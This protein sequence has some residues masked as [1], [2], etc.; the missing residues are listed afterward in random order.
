MT[1]DPSS[2]GAADQENE[3]F[4]ANEFSWNP[5]LMHYGT[6]VDYDEPCAYCVNIKHKY[7]QKENFD[8]PDASWKKMFLTHPTRQEFYAHVE[9]LGIHG[10]HNCNYRSS[11]VD[12]NTEVLTMEF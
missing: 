5:F 9:S 2:S 12:E 4:S 10:I 11:T 3:K 8:R 7:V 1:A 6:F